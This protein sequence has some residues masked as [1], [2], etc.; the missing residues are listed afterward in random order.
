MSYSKK[1]AIAAVVAA[2]V[3]AA[4]TIAGSTPKCGEGDVAGSIVCTY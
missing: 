2:V 4:A 1:V 3:V